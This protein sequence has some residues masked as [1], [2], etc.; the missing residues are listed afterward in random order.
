MRDKVGQRAQRQATKT[1]GGTLDNI[2]AGTAAIVALERV[3]KRHKAG[4]SQRPA[5]SVSDVKWRAGSGHP[6]D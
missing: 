3:R 2:H 5:Q 6:W 1:I 4:T